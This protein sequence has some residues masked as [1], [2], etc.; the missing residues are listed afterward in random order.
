MTIVTGAH[1]RVNRLGTVTR[2]IPTPSPFAKHISQSS[3]YSL[4]RVPYIRA[5]IRP[6]M[7]VASLKV[8]AKA[9]RSKPLKLC[10]IDL[11]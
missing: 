11:Q 4:E 7:D 10:V 8:F 1:D 2:H 6:G 3:N 9:L 5:R